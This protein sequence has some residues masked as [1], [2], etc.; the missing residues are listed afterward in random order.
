MHGVYY[1]LRYFVTEDVDKGLDRTTLSVG[2]PN[3]WGD[4][5]LCVVTLLLTL[6][7]PCTD[8]FVFVP[9]FVLHVMGYGCPVWL[10]VLGGAFFTVYLTMRPSVLFLCVG[11][12]L[13]RYLTGENRRVG[14]I[15]CGVVH[16]L[17][18]FFEP[19]RFTFL[20]TCV[21]MFMAECKLRMRWEW[22]VVPPL[23][24]VLLSGPMYVMN[25][26]MWGWTHRWR[27]TDKVWRSLDVIFPVCNVAAGLYLRN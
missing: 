19:F 14:L 15:F 12:L 10:T 11:A 5:W 16:L 6:P 22:E 25:V 2:V 1:L 20:G 26:F 27:Y 24:Y 21:V 23:S 9:Y 7:R 13:S 18:S 17:M 8:D 4:V 3:R